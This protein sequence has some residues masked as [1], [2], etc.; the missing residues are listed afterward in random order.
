MTVND[1]FD[2]FILSRRL[3]DLSQKTISD[4]RQFVRPFLSLVG[5]MDFQSLTQSDIGGYLQQ[6]L[7]RPISKATRATYIRHLKVFLKWC[8]D[9]YGAQYASRLVRVPRTPKKSVLIYSPDEVRQIFCA[10]E[11]G[12]PWI[13]ARNK[14]IVALMYDSG[15][16]QSE[17]CTLRRSMV[18]FPESRLVVHGKGDKE[19]VVPLGSLARQYMLSYLGACPYTLDYVFCGRR[20]APMTC[21]AVKLFF[22][23]LSSALPFEVSSHKLRHNFATNYCIDQYSQYGQ[24]DIYRL[25]YLM[26]HE[27]VE[28]TRL[29]LHHAHEIIAARGCISHLDGILLP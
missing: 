25:M 28:T 7:D 23:R 9:N 8:E 17:V 1:M 24:V 15:L 13:D 10:I 21:N 20:G 14:S 3:A 11:S 2:S 6:L 16:R 5:G 27:E 12:T 22:S 29:Y 18:S 4:Y 19:R 26:G